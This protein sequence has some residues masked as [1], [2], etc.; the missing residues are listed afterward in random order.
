MVAVT[1]CGAL[2]VPTW[3]L[4]TKLLGET[5]KGARP[6]PVSVTL[7][8]DPRLP[9]LS[10]KFRVPFTVPAADGVKV[11]LTVQVDP[12]ASVPTQLLVWA[13]SVP[14]TE[15]VLMLS[16]LPPKLETVIG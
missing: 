11:T 15:T 7:C 4:N 6:V 8:A 16:G 5:V 1:V 12:A 3:E 9:E 13:N 2:V 14:L 10:V